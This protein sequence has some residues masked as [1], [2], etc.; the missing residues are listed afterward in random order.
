MVQTAKLKLFNCHISLYRPLVPS[1]KTP[2]ILGLVC[3]PYSVAGRVD[4]VKRRTRKLRL[5]EGCIEQKESSVSF[6]SFVS[7]FL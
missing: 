6:V 5:P 4:A 3:M 7:K 2:A 1:F